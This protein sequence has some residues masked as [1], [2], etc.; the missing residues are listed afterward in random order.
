[1]DWKR[2]DLLGLEELDASEIECILEQAEAFK[3][4]STRPV[5][6][7]PALQG[8]TIVNFF[9]EPSTR[10]RASFELAAKRLSADIINMQG[11]TSSLTKGETL[12]DMALNIAA[13]K[14]ECIVIR[15]SSSG[16][17]HL[18]A[19]TV[20]TSIINAGDGSHEHPTQ[21]LLDLFTIRQKFPDL[22]GKRI[23]FVGDITHSRV[24]RS[25]IWGM[26]KLGARVTVCGPQTLIPIGIR[27]M[28]VEVTYDLKKALKQCDVLYL[29]RIQ[30]ERQR[31]YLIPSIRE[32]A[33]F[34]GVNPALLEDLGKELL[35][36]HPGPV[37]RGVELSGNLTER[38]Q[39]LILDQVTNGLAVRMAVLYLVAGYQKETS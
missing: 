13:L 37:N 22:K 21:A 11:T 4:I 7:V 38:K 32:Y 1:M 14:V 39:S 24:A 18:L 26:T 6:K 12:R 35:I 19:R 23:L 36:L 34:Y 16:A 17:P 29:L 20:D 9:L 10:T 30:H 27:A 8:K 2:K 5:K 33:R 3:E 31:T 25:N 15:H 28:G